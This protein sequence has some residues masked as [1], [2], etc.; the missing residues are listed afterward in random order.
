MNKEQENFTHPS[1]GQISFSRVQSNGT[2]FY[3]SELEQ[4]HFISLRISGSE[5]QRDLT[6]DRYY[7]TNRIVDLRLSSNQ[8][9]ELITSLNMGGGVPCTFEYIN[10]VKVEKLPEVENRKEFVH[11]KF[12]DRMQEFGANIAD[13]KERAKKII[14]KKTLSKDDQYELNSLLTSMS[15]EVTSN[16]PFFGKMFQ[17]TCDEIVQEAKTEID[18]AIQHKINTL[19]LA[20]LHNQQKLLDK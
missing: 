9:A 17:E 19:G 3:G 20:E 8:F 7:P 18:N 10:N 2:R 14:A 16:I 15:Q 6:C 11:R 5:I 13:R 1:F 12:E 4:D